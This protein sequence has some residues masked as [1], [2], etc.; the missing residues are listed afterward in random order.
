MIIE[1]SINNESTAKI[2]KIFSITVLVG[3]MLIVSSCAS[4][5]E[6][7]TVYEYKEKNLTRQIT[8]SKSVY[9]DNTLTIYHDGFSSEKYSVQ[10]I[11]TNNNNDYMDSDTWKY[12]IDDSKIIITCDNAEDINSLVITDENNDNDY[13]LRWLNTDQYAVLHYTFADDAGMVI[14]E[15]DESLYY[16]KE[17]LEESAQKEAEYKAQQE[18]IWNRIEGYYETVIS[19]EFMYFITLENGSRCVYQNGEYIFVDFIDD[20]DGHITIFYEKSALEYN[21]N[22]K[23]SDDGR[24]LNEEKYIYVDGQYERR[25]VRYNKTKLKTYDNEKKALFEQVIGDWCQMEGSNVDIAI[26]SEFYEEFLDGFYIYEEFGHYLI[27]ATYTYPISDIIKDGDSIVVIF[28]DNG[29]KRTLHCSKGTEENERLLFI[30]ET[31]GVLENIY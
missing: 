12:E 16:T 26:D 14:D 22:L 13:Y 31:N 23:L 3:V 21:I 20:D 25:L 7:G 28:Y 9:K 24:Y 15:G 6:D 11:S 2:K 8:I 27:C 29:I 4:K 10:Y 5:K 17:E 1:R 18:Q 30:E 19:G